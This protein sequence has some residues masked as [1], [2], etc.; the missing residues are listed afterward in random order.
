MSILFLVLVVFGMEC[1][2]NLLG[3]HL[4]DRVVGDEVLSGLHFCSCCV[5]NWWWQIEWRACPITL[6]SQE[7]ASMHRDFGRQERSLTSRWFYTTD[8]EQSV[9]TCVMS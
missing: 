1:D 3:S 6:H 4:E 9:Q 7:V 8:S 5:V 2:A